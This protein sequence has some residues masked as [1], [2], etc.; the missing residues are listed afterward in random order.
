MVFHKFQKIENLEKR[1]EEILCHNVVVTE[2]IHGTSFRFVVFHPSDNKPP[3]FGSRN[4][5]VT[6]DDNMFYGAQP[7]HFIYQKW[8]DGAFNNLYWGKYTDSIA[9]YGEWAGDGVMAGIRYGVPNFYCYQVRLNS[10]EVVNDLSMR[11]ICAEVNLSTVPLICSGKIPI[12]MLKEIL[13]MDSFILKDTEGKQVPNNKLEGV[14]ITVEPHICDADGDLYMVKF[15]NEEFK[16]RVK[17][18]KPKEIKSAAGTSLAEEFVTKGRILNV[19]SHGD[20]PIAW[21]MVDM[22]YLSQLVPAD[23]KEEEA[24]AWE[25]ALKEVSEGDIRSAICK[26]VVSLYKEILLERSLSK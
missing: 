21:D 14:V 18:K 3:I 16:E 2:K 9:F 20:F 8:Q 12:E 22:K 11:E 1:A 23:V 5:E 15:K 6:L 24:D 10:E 26:K 7:Q 4:Q 17:V 25:E 19:I 13:K